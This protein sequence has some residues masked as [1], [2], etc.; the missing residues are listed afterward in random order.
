M[1]NTVNT[2]SQNL[3]DSV[4]VS[5]LFTMWDKNIQDRVASE[6]MSKIKNVKDKSMCR[7]RKSLIPSHTA[8]A[9]IQ[10]LHNNARKFLY[11]N[12]FA[13]KF[14]GP[15]ILTIENYESVISRLREFEAEFNIAVPEFLEQYDTIRE[16]AKE[17]LGDLF[18][19]ADYPAVISLKEKFNFSISVDALPY[20]PHLLS[21][22]L[23]EAEVEKINKAHE[24]SLNSVL[25][26]ATNEMWSK[27]QGR[28]VTMYDN[29]V[30]P[31]SKVRESTLESL[32]NVAELLPKINITNDE[33]L[34]SVCDNIL[35]MLV[36]ESK[37][38]LDVD[39]DKREKIALKLKGTK[40]LIEVIIL[41][42]LGIDTSTESEDSE[43]GDDIAAVAA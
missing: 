25:E 18:D 34:N 9:T 31:K 19:E 7:V 6:E 36:T 17:K 27:L 4:L 40:E 38:S 12:T 1:T 23:S 32:I 3:K 37:Q 42:N 10:E 15:R 33:R 20:A 8:L 21:L 35:D 28:V 30:N 16:D 13:W 26:N 11:E 41:D 14:K 2:P 22:G 5:L 39:P 24:D 29:L 43:D